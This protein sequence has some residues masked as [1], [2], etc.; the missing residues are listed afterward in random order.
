MGL[1]AV[2]RKAKAS[3]GAIT[4]K[5]ESCTHSHFVLFL[6]SDSTANSLY[7]KVSSQILWLDPLAKCLYYMYWWAKDEVS[8][9]NN[10][11]EDTVWDREFQK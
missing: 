1:L 9:E 11:K 4:P 5:R 2:E 10:G 7:H 8:P 3:P 6:Q